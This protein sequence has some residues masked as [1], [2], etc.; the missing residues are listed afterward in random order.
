[1]N[2]VLVVA[3]LVERFSQLLQRPLRTRVRGQVQVRQAAP[4]MLNNDEPVPDPERGRDGDEEIA[5]EDGRRVVLQARRPALLAKWVSTGPLRHAL[6]NRS[7]PRRRM[8]P[9][10]RCSASCCMAMR[11]GSAAT[12]PTRA[13][14][15]PS[16][17]RRRTLRTSPISSASEALH[18][19]G[20]QGE[21][22]DQVAHPC[23]GRALDRGD[24]ALVRLNQHS[25]PSA[26][27]RTLGCADVA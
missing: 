8:P 9:I 27:Q 23:S 26:D 19:G 20:D 2:Q 1:M 17:P 5:G 21:E 11:G 3:A 16:E 22:P 15:M 7:R 12:R 6:A 13:R 10:A 25:L 14:A 18:R 4:A 24:Q